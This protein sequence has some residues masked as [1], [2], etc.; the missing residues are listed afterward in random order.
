MP[1]A[2]VYTQPRSEIKFR[3]DTTKYDAA[4]K[5]SEELGY[6]T[7]NKY[8]EHLIDD[9]LLMQAFEQRKALLAQMKVDD[10]R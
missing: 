2:K 10:A 4:V 1:R 9:D 3:V 8:L 5:R 6:K 7:F